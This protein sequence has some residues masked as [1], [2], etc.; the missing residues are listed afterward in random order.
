MKTLSQLCKPRR[1]VFD[2]S[3]RDTV[4]DLTDLI[5]GKINPNEFFAESYMTDGMKR[6]LRESFRRF[7]GLSDQGIFVLSQAMG[8]GKTHN[9]VALG[10][11]AQHPELRPAVMEGLNKSKNLGQVLADVW[12][13]VALGELEKAQQTIEAVPTQ[14]PFAQDTCRPVTYWAKSTKNGFELADGT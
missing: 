8:G 7:S 3:R 9:M 11:L 10:L 14:H 4:L 2:P 1:S 6:L 12:I 5:Q 13:N